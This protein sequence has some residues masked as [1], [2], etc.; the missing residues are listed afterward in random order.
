L[1][2]PFHRGARGPRP[3]IYAMVT[4]D[5]QYVIM[6][7]EEEHRDTRTYLN[8]SSPSWVR[9]KFVSVM[10][11]G[12]ALKDVYCCQ[13][14]TLLRR[15]LS[16]DDVS[17]FVIRLGHRT[18]AVEDISRNVGILL[19]TWAASFLWRTV[20][21]CESGQM[22]NTYN[23]LINPLTPE[24][25]PSAQRCLTRFFT[26]DFASWTVHFVH[27]C[28]KNQ[29]I[30]QLFIQ[31]IMYGSCYMFR[32]FIAILRERSWCLLRDAQLRRSR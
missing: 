30:H 32:H 22:M 2:L 25:N 17:S 29:Q 26:G 23:C 3:F 16:D 28:V 13:N 18:P 19:P 12:V 10:Q 27:I 15:M 7:A 20:L 4:P 1:R 6:A 14:L 5:K 21:R 9:S 11:T 8:A 31:F 24:L